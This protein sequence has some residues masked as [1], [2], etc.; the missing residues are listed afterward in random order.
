MKRGIRLFLCEDHYV[1]RR[2]LREVLT[3]EGF[4]VVG[5]APSIAEALEGIRKATVDIVLVDLTMG[6]DDD[7]PAIITHLLNVF[8]DLKI[9]VFS[10]RE[11]LYTISA[12]YMAGAL[13]YVTKRSDPALLIEAIRLVEGGG[14]YFMPGISEQIRD[15]KLSAK[16]VDPR[17]VLVE[18]DLIVFRMVANGSSAAEIAKSLNRKTQTIANRISAI[19]NKLSCSRADLKV[20]AIKY[21]IIKLPL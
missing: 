12:A 2:G 8:P 4:R 10:M 15:Y 7:G 6:E 13:G 16:E 3:D 11:Q 14:R 5:E 17:Q 9:I 1:L 19:C 20:I 18:M 21:E